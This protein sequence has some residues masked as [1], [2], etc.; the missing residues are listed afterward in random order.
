MTVGELRKAM[1]G[2]DDSVPVTIFLGEDF[3]K[4]GGVLVTE[5]MAHTRSAK[6]CKPTGISGQEFEITMG[7]LFSY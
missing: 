2:V 3:V 5:Y 7:N 4:P 1:D 6:Y